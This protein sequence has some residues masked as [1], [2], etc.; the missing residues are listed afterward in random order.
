MSN[1]KIPTLF[2]SGSQDELIPV[3][4][5]EDLY[6]LCLAEKEFV[7]FRN[8]THNDTCIQPGYFE[9][10]QEFWEKKGSRGRGRSLRD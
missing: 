6:E 1:I 9:A 5:M 8:G 4:H 7:R 3:S 2:L 10:I